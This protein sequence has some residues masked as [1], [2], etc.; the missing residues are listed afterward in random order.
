[1]RRR[2]HIL[3]DKLPAGRCLIIVGTEG[4]HKSF[5]TF[6]AECLEAL[7]RLA[8]KPRK[9][10][11]LSLGSMLPEAD[12]GTSAVTT[13]QQIVRVE[14]GIFCRGGNP[15]PDLVHR[16]GAADAAMAVSIHVYGSRFDQV[17]R[18]RYR[19]DGTVQ[20]R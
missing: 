20:N 13:P 10:Y 2:L 19:V 11:L 4:Q 6:V 17:C 7:D 5:D 1:V 14:P 8:A 16:I 12:A 3:K 15:I 18:N 9:P